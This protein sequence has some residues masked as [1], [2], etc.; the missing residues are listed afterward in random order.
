MERRK[1]MAGVAGMLGIAA[2]KPKL[3]EAFPTGDGLAADVDWNAVLKGLDIPTA[4]ACL[5]ERTW[6]YR[7]IDY[8]ATIK[9]IGSVEVRFSIGTATI[10]AQFSNHPWMRVGSFAAASNTKDVAAFLLPLAPVYDGP[11][12]EIQWKGPDG[13]P[14]VLHRP[15]KSQKELDDRLSVE[16]Y[17]DERSA[18]IQKRE[19]NNTRRHWHVCVVTVFHENGQET[20]LQPVPEE[21]IAYFRR[22]GRVLAKEIGQA[23]VVAYSRIAEDR[24]LEEQAAKDAIALFA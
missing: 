16:K 3:D 14:L 21:V 18:R 19:Q 13:K 1:F 11:P 7:G 9:Y 12:A 17:L 5:A 4:S 6:T 23:H 8:R 10:V 15:A 24:R 2:A 20:R 22:M